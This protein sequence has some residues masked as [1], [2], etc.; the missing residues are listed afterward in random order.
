MAL[1]TVQVTSVHRLCTKNC[2]E[3]DIKTHF[4]RPCQ[5]GY[6]ILYMGKY[7]EIAPRKDMDYPPANGERWS[8]H[9]WLV[10]FDE[11]GSVKRR[12]VVEADSL[13]TGQN[14]YRFIIHNFAEPIATDGA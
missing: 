14:G 2:M 3:I 10:E 9:D 11:S 13:L 6:A 5:P 8:P 1:E 7:V 4:G 12:T